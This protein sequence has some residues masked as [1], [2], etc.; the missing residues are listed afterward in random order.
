MVGPVLLGNRKYSQ[1]LGRRLLLWQ[2]GLIANVK[3]HFL[4]YVDLSGINIKISLSLP[5]PCLVKFRVGL[6]VSMLSNV[7]FISQIEGLV[8][9]L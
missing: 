8:T 6:Y 1:C 2:A 3:L 4:K 7:D 5:E 9:C